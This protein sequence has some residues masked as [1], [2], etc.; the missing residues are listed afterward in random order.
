MKAIEKFDNVIA[1]GR[2]VIDESINYT[3]FRAYRIGLKTK[4]DTI[5][6]G[7]VIWNQDVEGVVETLREFGFESFTISNT[8]SGMTELVAEFLKHGCKLAGM[9]VVKTQYEDWMT[10]KLNTAPAFVIEL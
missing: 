1:Q 7:E 9:T 3:V 10:G 4:N 2:E 8:A 6:F 5:D